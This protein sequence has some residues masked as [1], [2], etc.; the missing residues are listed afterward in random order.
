MTE[1]HSIT[2]EKF[3]DPICGMTV[4]PETAAAIMEHNG[5]TV[6]FCSKVCLETFKQRIKAERPQPTPVG[7]NKR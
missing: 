7:I 6:Y 4:K 5:E 2:S 1:K 3:I